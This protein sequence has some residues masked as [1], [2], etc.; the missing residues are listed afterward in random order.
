MGQ[1]NSRSKS[2]LIVQLPKIEDP[3]DIDDCFWKIEA[4]DKDGNPLLDG[5]KTVLGLVVEG[6]SPSTATY[7]LMTK[8]GRT[9]PIVKMG[10]ISEVL[11][12]LVVILLCHCSKSQGGKI[13]MDQTIC[14][15]ALDKLDDVPR[16]TDFFPREEID[17]LIVT[18]N[19]R[20]LTHAPQEELLEDFKIRVASLT[21]V[22]PKDQTLLVNGKPLLDNKKSLQELGVKNGEKILLSGK[23]I[24]NKAPPTQKLTT[25]ENSPWTPS[26]ARPKV[27][28]E[29]ATF[30][31]PLG[32]QVLYL[33]TTHTFTLP[34]DGNVAYLQEKIERQLGIPLAKQILLFQGKP[35][36]SSVNIKDMYQA[37]RGMNMLFTLFGTK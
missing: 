25:G 14:N 17:L 3:R 21:G 26:S 29:T 7:G 13:S 18:F 34:D 23:T 19:K 6:D 22:Q 33:N 16:H 24:S 12:E 5:T 37:N 27:I 32:V 1:K 10:S 20:Y 36:S 15:E 31:E 35:V 28:F 9:G 2:E 30:E 4:C 11:S 8:G